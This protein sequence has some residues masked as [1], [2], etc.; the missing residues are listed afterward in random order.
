M[1]TLIVTIPGGEP[2]HTDFIGPPSAVDDEEYRE[3]EE[4]RRQG[5]R[6]WVLDSEE[7]WLLQGS[8]Y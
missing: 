2:C 6:L 8:Y 3:P 1:D 7:G 4:L 5:K